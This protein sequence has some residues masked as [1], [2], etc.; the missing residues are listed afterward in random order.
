MR[1]CNQ[2]LQQRNEVGFSRVKAW[3]KLTVPLLC[4]TDKTRSLGKANVEFHKVLNQQVYCVAWANIQIY[5]TRDAFDEAY[6][7]SSGLFN[8]CDWSSPQI[9]P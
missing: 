1:K 3:Q 2:V 5:G 6:T 4:T 8:E 9:Y 7:T